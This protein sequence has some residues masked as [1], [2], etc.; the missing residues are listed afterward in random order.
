MA[1]CEYQLGYI[2][3]KY[4]EK[5]G[6][7]QLTSKIDTDELDDYFMGS[8]SNCHLTAYNQYESAFLYF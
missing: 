7:T 4:A 3:H 8:V 2:Y 1:L 5:L 6:L